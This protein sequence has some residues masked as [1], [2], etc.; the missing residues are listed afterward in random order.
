MP[1]RVISR[2]RPQGRRSRPS[3]QRGLQRGSG[4]ALIVL[5]L[6]SLATLLVRAP[7]V[8]TRQQEQKRFQAWQESVVEEPDAVE[9][10][11]VEMPRLSARFPSD[12]KEIQSLLEANPTVAAVVNRRDPAWVLMPEDGALAPSDSPLAARFSSWA[13]AAMQSGAK[14]NP[15]PE[16]DP[17]AATVPSLVLPGPDWIFI[18]RWVIGS[19]AVERHLRL[20]LG[21]HPR[22]RFGVWRFDPAL[23]GP[24]PADPSPFMP[25]H[26]QAWP[27]SELHRWNIS[28]TSTDLGPDWEMICQPWPAE[29]EAWDRELAEQR[30]LA[31]GVAAAIAL[32]LLSGFWLRRASGRR[33][34]LAADRVASLTHSLKTPLALHK[35]RCDSLRMG[36][37]EP[38]RARQ[39]LM[40]L[41][42]EVDELTHLI[43]RGLRGLQPDGGAEDRQPIPPSWFRDLAE[44]MAPAFGEGGRRLSIEVAEAAGSAHEPS[45]HSALQTLLENACHHGRGDA[46]LRTEA[47]KGALRIQVSDRGPGLDQAALDALGRP[48]Q[49]LRAEGEEGFATPGQ[50]LGL[51]L[52]FLLA[53]Q[54][55]WGLEL[56]S[57]PGAGLTTVLSIPRS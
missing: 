49:R 32:A 7:Q 1:R 34:R 18:K 21:P 41:G 22:V 23:H 56:S 54:E 15:P 14:W 48:F 52:L 27:G 6:A 4:L 40:R 33:E 28:L 10:L 43:E 5:A 12:P 2:F 57:D 31:W 53:K 25:P 37:L 11:F 46:A 17:D 20:A 45:L 44:E 16:M 13:R 35:L 50:G 42:Q 3:W 51:S 29:A 30:R 19:G 26:L 39:E 47:A 36:S 55:G 9:H 38:A 24:A 8:W